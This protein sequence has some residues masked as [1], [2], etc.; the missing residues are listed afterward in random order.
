VPDLCYEGAIIDHVDINGRSALIHAA[1]HGHL[2]V[3]EALVEQGAS[4]KIVAKNGD[5]AHYL[6]IEVY[7]KICNLLQEV[8]PTNSLVF[9]NGSEILS[10][11][12][13][14]AL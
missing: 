11:Q 10:L 1:Q 6:A 8:L 4:T 14:L 5:T 2:N 3:I 7:H 13:Q 9:S 12:V